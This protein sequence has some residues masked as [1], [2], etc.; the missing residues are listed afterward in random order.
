MTKSSSVLLQKFITDEVDQSSELR[1]VYN[2]IQRNTSFEQLVYWL[3]Y[4]LEKSYDFA[5]LSDE[6]AKLNV[7]RRDVRSL[8]D[9]FAEMLGNKIEELAD[10]EYLFVAPTKMEDYCPFP[11]EALV[12][13]TNRP[14][15]RV[16][17]FD[18]YRWNIIQTK[19]EETP[20]YHM[21]C[22]QIERI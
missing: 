17:M 13:Y 19:L 3:K 8:L 20:Y 2:I 11:S 22:S 1:M 16:P 9:I 21:T 5:Y 4:S 7:S 18:G 10:K 15:D 14:L 6:G 12:L